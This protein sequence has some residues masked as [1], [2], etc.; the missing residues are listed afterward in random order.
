MFQ[1]TLDLR[2]SQLTTLSVLALQPGMPA[3]YM[4]SLAHGL[5]HGLLISTVP[6]DAPSLRGSDTLNFSR[7]CGFW[8]SDLLKR[9]YPLSHKHIY[10]QLPED[11]SHHHKRHNQSKLRHPSNMPFVGAVSICLF[12]FRDSQF[13][14]YLVHKID[15][16]VFMT[17]QASRKLTL[18]SQKYCRDCG[19]KFERYRRILA[20]TSRLGRIPHPRF[21]SEPEVLMI[22]TNLS[23]LRTSR[24]AKSPV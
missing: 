17:I 15:A 12:S 22:V 21:H 14:F 4:L 1:Y 6:N 13:K 3:H 19:L 16:S 7:K 5:F 10:S 2:Q 11:P 8:P 18:V 23:P 20:V 24:I 9:F